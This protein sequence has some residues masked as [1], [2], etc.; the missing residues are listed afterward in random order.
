MKSR[1]LISIIVAAMLAL[2]SMSIYAEQ[3]RGGGGGG[4]RDQQMDRDRDFDRDRT[5]DRIDSDARAGD[6]D[7]DRDRDRDQDKDRDKDQARDRDRDQDRLHTENP[8]SMSHRDIYGSELM[9][10]EEVNQ[11][12]KQL[13]NMETRQARE[14][15]QIQHEKQMQAR[16]K[17]QGKDLVPPGQGPVYGGELMTVEER[18]Q[19]REQLR[20]TDG[21]EER[22][23]LQAQHR[24]KM[25]ARAK[26]LKLEIAAIE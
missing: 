17:Q 1:T 22:L 15:F 11:Y 24:E 6:F 8:M 20:L 2:T 9:T 19:Y 12:R 26:A 10:E 23:Q 7:K 4:D 14:Q 3:G 13:A 18:N 21:E 25:N 16:A 5:R